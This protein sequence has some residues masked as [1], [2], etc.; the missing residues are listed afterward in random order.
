MGAACTALYV[1][2][3]EPINTPTNTMMNW[4]KIQSACVTP[5]RDTPYAS[6]I[7]NMTQSTASSHMSLAITKDPAPC[8]PYVVRGQALAVQGSIVP[9]ERTAVVIEH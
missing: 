3:R 5:D 8:H 6:N 4:L 1:N 9:R 2:S 7:Q